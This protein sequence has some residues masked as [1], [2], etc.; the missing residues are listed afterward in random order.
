MVVVTLTLGV[1]RLLPQVVFGANGVYSGYGGGGVYSTCREVGVLFG[2]LYVYLW[3]LRASLACVLVSP[4]ITY[5]RPTFVFR[6]LHC[7][8]YVFSLY[9]RVG[10]QVLVRPF[11]FVYV[12]VV[13]ANFVATIYTVA[14][15]SVMANG[16]GGSF[17]ASM[18]GVEVFLCGAV[19]REGR[20]VVTCEG[21]TVVF[22]VFVT[23]FS[24]LVCSGFNYGSIPIRVVVV[25]RVV[26]QGRGQCFAQEG[27]GLPYVRVPVFV[28]YHRIVGTSRSVSLVVRTLDGLIGF[29]GHYR[30]LVMV[31]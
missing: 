24:F 18:E 10:V 20:V 16:N 22:R 31:S 17:D 1:F 4:Y 21:A 11:C 12:R 7:S 26:L 15:G 28:H 27:R 23:S 9:V 2:L 5:G 25:A 14:G 30:G 8:N 29:V 13:Q 6:D 3:S 19:S